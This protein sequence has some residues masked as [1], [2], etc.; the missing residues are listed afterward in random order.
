MAEP[1]RMNRDEVA[2]AFALEL[3]TLARKHGA[4]RLNMTFDMTGYTK[5]WRERNQWD[6]GQISLSWQN[7]RHGDHDQIHLSYQSSVN[8]LELIEE[9]SN[10]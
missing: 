10:A 4:N 9:P 5:D 3:V 7:G 8:L 6:R 2:K 1:D